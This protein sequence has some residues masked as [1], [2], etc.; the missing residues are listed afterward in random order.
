L[1]LFFV[2][3][4][5]LD[6]LREEFFAERKER[7]RLQAQKDKMKRELEASQSRIA[8]LQEQ[9]MAGLYQILL[10]VDQDTSCHHQSDGNPVLLSQLNFFCNCSWL[11]V[12]N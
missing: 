8:S 3:F 5:K 1:I 10:I 2:F 4:P 12:A 7:E 6:S 11:A 9:V